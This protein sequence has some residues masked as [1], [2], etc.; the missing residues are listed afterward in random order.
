MAISDLLYPS[1]E[2][3]ENYRRHSFNLWPKG[4]FFFIIKKVIG[5]QCSFIKY[6]VYLRFL[7]TPYKAVS[8]SRVSYWILKSRDRRHLRMLCSFNYVILA[9]YF[10]LM[11]VA[12]YVFDLRT[13]T[14]KPPIWRMAFRRQCKL[15][16]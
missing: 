1:S 11:M 10:C 7:R 8:G 4:G 6:I 16:L 12:K 3:L 14:W 13:S 2:S 9:T 5:N 15:K